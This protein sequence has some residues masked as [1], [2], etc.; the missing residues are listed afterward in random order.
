MSSNTS[1]VMED[2]P[3]AMLEEAAIWQAKLRE[4]V[5]DAVVKRALYSDFNQWLLVDI[6]HRQ[7]FS[8]MEDLWGMLKAPVVHI[9]TDS[10][11]GGDQPEISALAVSDMAALSSNHRIFAQ[12]LQR[13]A[14]ASSFVLAVLLT[15]GWHQDWI[16]QWQSDYI[17]GIG[18]EAPIKTNDGSS[19]RLNTDSALAVNYSTDERQVRLLKGEAWFDVASGDKRP[20]IVTTDNGV[21]KVTGTQFNVR[22]KKGATIVSLDEGRVEL[23][24][25][26]AM[27]D[28]PVILSSGQ[29]AVLSHEGIAG[30]TPFDRTAELAWLRGQ[31]VFYETP[32][33]DVVDTL[34]RHRHGR[35]I[36]TNKALRNLKVSGVFSTHDSNTALKMITNTLPI[37]QIRLTDY[38]IL[39]R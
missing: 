23:R 36:I 38:L 1:K 20:F 22:F 16:M 25:A 19:I 7:A 26:N 8:E 27:V 37:S 21:V 18:E 4:P 35:I 13:L 32:L 28:T 12:P 24:A 3:E 11:L 33:A 29:Q 31:F 34:N 6:R 30:V 39:L 10:T 17:T 9:V 5:E 2:L 15:L 14:I